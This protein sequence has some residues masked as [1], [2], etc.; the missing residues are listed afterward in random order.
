LRVDVASA[1]GAE[2]LALGAV[3][4]GFPDERASGAVSAS[5]RFT[6]VVFPAQGSFA[7]AVERISEPLEE[8]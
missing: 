1:A 6:I 2:R 7:E 8:W 5:V 4:G 3:S